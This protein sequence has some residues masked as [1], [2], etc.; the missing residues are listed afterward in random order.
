MLHGRC[1]HYVTYEPLPHSTILL[2]TLGVLG[3]LKWPLAG[4]LI[5]RRLPPFQCILLV[6]GRQC[7]QTPLSNAAPRPQY[8]L[9]FGL[10]R[11][12]H[13]GKLQRPD[14]IVLGSAQHLIPLGVLQL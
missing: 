4:R 14:E 10:V 8:P 12:W 2:Q 5:F 3:Q 6:C 9:Q 7:I 11:I 1:P 13:T